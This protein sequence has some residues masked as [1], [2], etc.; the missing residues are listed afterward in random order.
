MDH[1]NSQEEDSIDGNKSQALHMP[2]SASQVEH[3]RSSSLDSPPPKS[4]MDPT[5]MFRNRG[6]RTIRTSAQN[7]VLTSSQ[8]S[9]SLSQSSSSSLSPVK[10]Y[11][12]HGGPPPT[13]PTTQ[14]QQGKYRSRY[15]HATTA[16]MSS[17]A[18]ST[19]QNSGTSDDV[20]GEGSHHSSHHMHQ[21]LQKEPPQRA[22]SKDNQVDMNS[23]Q[24]NIN[25]ERIIYEEEPENYHPPQS[26]LPSDREDQ[27]TTSQQYN[28]DNN[29]DAQS[30]ENNEEP[31][32]ESD[33]NNMQ[34]NASNIIMNRSQDSINDSINSSEQYAHSAVGSTV[35]IMGSIVG[36][37]E[38]DDDG[39]NETRLLAVKRRMMQ[40]VQEVLEE[41]DQDE[42]SE[43]ANAEDAMHSTDTLNTSLECNADT[44]T[45]LLEDIDPT[46]H[47]T[48]ANSDQDVDNRQSEKSNVI[49]VADFS[50]TGNLGTD[51]KYTINNIYDTTT[52]NNES[53]IRAAFRRSAQ[54]MANHLPPLSSSSG[55]S[56][57]PFKRLTPNRF[58]RATASSAI[59]KAATTASLIPQ[60]A[61]QCFSFEDTTVDDDHF[62]A[63]PDQLHNINIGSGEGG[64]QQLATHKYYGLS[65]VASIDDCTTEQ[66]H[67]NYAPKWY[68]PN[69]TR[70]SNNGEHGNNPFRVIRH[71]QT[72]DP[73]GRPSSMRKYSNDKRKETSNYFE[74]S[75]R[76]T[77]SF[78]PWSPQ[79]SSGRVKPLG[80]KIEQFP[81]SEAL[82]ST[83]QRL[84]NEKKDWKVSF[85]CILSLSFY[86]GE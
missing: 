18:Q 46:Y 5:G 19:A 55:T 30:I 64:Q 6:R 37:E 31:T 47:E 83:T 54:G 36:E 49:K 50:D 38:G 77:S 44:D 26:T 61:R 9:S 7:G 3:H 24:N 12:R 39:I 43:G 78:D 51:D 2:K 62:L 73:D 40:D 60:L 20:I 52:T 32:H 14:Q 59:D 1:A 80:N 75:L 45:A 34:L 84:D 15:E 70:L 17:S 22:I 57:S 82:D 79:L 65:A 56:G 85:D 69:R 42:E 74:G 25:T 67:R 28:I 48:D 86:L 13:S 72:W 10:N 41:E 4:K 11:K 76:Q 71:S 81:I 27:V 66:S 16:S 58:Q 35:S 33:E 8:S 68:P 53:P 23:M 29:I 21:S 63:M